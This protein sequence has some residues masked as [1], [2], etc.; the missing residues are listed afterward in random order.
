MFFTYLFQ[1]G[2]LFVYH[3]YRPAISFTLTPICIFSPRTTKVASASVTCF[4]HSYS[5]PK[6]TKTSNIYQFSTQHF[7]SNDEDGW[8][9]YELD[10]SGRVIPSGNAQ[11][12]KTTNIDKNHRS[13]HDRNIQK[14]KSITDHCDMSPKSHPSTY[15]SSTNFETHDTLYDTHLK[16]LIKKREKKQYQQIQSISSTNRA[17]NFL[18]SR[19]TGEIIVLVAI[20]LIF[21][22]WCSQNFYQS[23]FMLL[24]QKSNIFLNK[25]ANEMIYFNN[26]IEE[27][28]LCHKDYQRKLLFCWG[29]KQKLQNMLEKYIQLHVEKITISPKSLRSLSH[30][31]AMYRLTE[32]Q[33]AHVLVDVGSK[34]IKTKNIASAQKLLFYGQRIFKT[35]KAHLFLVPLRSRLSEFYHEDTT[36]GN[37]VIKETQETMGLTAYKAAVEAEGKNQTELTEGWDLLGLTKHQAQ[38]IWIEVHKDF[39]D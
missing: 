27:L 10:M 29:R 11:S 7:S 35:P 37:D 33:A 13:I 5:F 18:K 19:D 1:N 34:F 4:F 8:L 21:T 26:D 36:N 38:E 24:T 14:S 12:T 20:P 22:Y 30:V 31:F 2:I 39:F 6:L 28:E 25:Y 15:S 9:P 16:E 23:I 3:F 32:S 17:S